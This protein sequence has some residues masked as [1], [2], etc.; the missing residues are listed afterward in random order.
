VTRAIA[1]R[2]RSL[3]GKGYGRLDVSAARLGLTSDAGAAVPQ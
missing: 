1:D 3:V 2:W